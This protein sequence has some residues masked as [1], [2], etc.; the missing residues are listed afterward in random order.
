MTLFCLL[1]LYKYDCFFHLVTMFVQFRLSNLINYVGVINVIDSYTWVFQTLKYT[2]IVSDQSREDQIII[3]MKL[4][5]RRL[6]SHSSGEEETKLRQRRRKYV[7]WIGQKTNHMLTR[8]INL[9]LLKAPHLKEHVSSSALR[10][11]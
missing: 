9:H 5:D 7:F 10:H 3:V 1:S 11:T 4:R 8:G 6:M 2:R